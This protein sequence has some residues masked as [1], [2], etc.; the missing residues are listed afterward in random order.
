ME[1][2]FV[3]YEISSRMEDIGFEEPTLCYYDSDTQKIKQVCPPISSID[4]P[5][6][7]LFY[8]KHN[9]KHLIPLIGAP[10]YQQVFDWFRKE[11]KLLGSI[12]TEG[13]GKYSYTINGD[14]NEFRGSFDDIKIKCI[15]ELILIVNKKI[16]K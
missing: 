10:L 7:G 4:K 5:M 3:S 12:K 8:P 6:F 13:G 16:N 14:E 2:L 1:D 11:Y 15:M 9:K